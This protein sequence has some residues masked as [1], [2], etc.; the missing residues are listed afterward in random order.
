[1]RFFAILAFSTFLLG[2]QAIAQT[3]AE[4]VQEQLKANPNAKWHEVVDTGLFISDTFL[5]NGPTGEV[6][7][8]KGIAIKVGPNEEHTLVFD[9]ETM[10]MVAGFKGNVT[11][12]GTPWDGKH[13]G[14]SYFPEEASAYFFQT[15]MGPGWAIDG[16]WSDPREKDNGRP[17]GP[18]PDE[19]AEYLGLYRNTD[20]I[21]L[22]YTVGGSKVLEKPG[23]LGDSLLRTIQLE[24]TA[25]PTE[26]LISDPTETQKNVS[27]LNA[28]EGV[29]LKTLESGR[30]VVSIPA[31]I[32]GQ[33]HIVYWNGEPADTKVES[34]D[35]TTFTEG[36]P[37]MFPE[38]V[39]VS[40][41]LGQEDGTYAV[42]SI[43]LPTENPWKSQ[44]RFGGFDIFSDGD[45]A[46]CSTWN[47]DVWIAEGIGGDLDKVTWRRFASGLYQT[48][49]LKIVDDVVYTQGRDQIT[50]LHDL[51]DDGEAD[52]YEC[53]NNDVRIT[54]GFHE[55]TFDLQTDKE[56]NFY[57]TKAQ[58][59]LAGGRGFAP[60]TP[61]NGTILKISPDGEKLERVAW[62]IRA[63]GGI[64]V[65]PN[66]ELTT[67][68]NEGSY[69]PR[70]KI[71]WSNPDGGS[72]HG[73]VPSVWEEKAFV[74]TLDGA[75]TDY[76]RPLCWLPYYVDNSSGSQFW[77]PEDSAWKTHAGHMLHLSY[78]K[79]SVYRTLIDK[80]DGQVQGGVYRLPIELTT[81]AMRGRFHPESGNLFLIGFRGWQTNGGTGFQRVRY[82]GNEKPVPT[83]LKAHKNGIIVKFSKELDKEVASDPRRYAVSKWDYV[84]GPQYGSGR[85]SIDN[86]DDEA[87][88]KA[89]SEAS[90]G[91]QN[92]IDTVAVRA[93][94]LLGD[95]KTV[96]LYIPDMTPAMQM[97][98]K[99]DLVAADKEAFRETIWNT[100][101]NLRPDFGEHGLDL[102]NLP[103][104]NTEPVGEPG[105]I[106]SMAHGSTDD[107]LVV[108]RLAITLDVD[109]AATP[110]ID[111]RRGREMVFEG[112]LVVPSRDN[113]SFKMDGVGW[114]SL[115]I[116]GETVAEG[117]LP[118]T[119]DPIELEAGPHNIFCNFQRTDG[120][121]GKRTTGG[122][123]RLRLLWSGTDFVWEP[124]P[125]TAYRHLSNAV[126]EAKDKTRHGRD[127]FASVGCIRCHD[128]G[129]SVDPKKA[130]PE[131]L[132]TLP[133]FVNAGN[134]W[135]RGWVEEW[136]RKPEDRCPSV[137][138]DDAQ[139]IAAYL[140]TL[141][142]N[143]LAEQKG[144]AEKGKAL[145][146]SLHF[147]KWAEE[148][149]ADAKHT[150]AGLVAFLKDPTTHYADTTFPHLRLSDEE[151]GDLAAWIISNQPEPLKP[152]EG[153][154]AKGKEMVSKRCLVCHGGEEK[155]SYEF[156]A[157]PLSEMWQQEWLVHGCLSE[158]EG[159]APE[160]G[161]T[162]DEKQALLAFKNVDSNGGLRSLNRFV[163]HEYATRTMERIGCAECHSGENELP[164]I[165]FAGEKLRDEWLTGLFHGDVLRIRPYQ[166]ARMP[167]FPSR[168]ETLA[169][170]IAHGAGVTTGEKLT[171]PDPPLAEAGEKVSGLTGYACITCHAAGE[172]GAMQA[173]E[174]Q[175]PNLQLAGERLR[176]DYYMS[177]MHW[178]QRFVP[179]TIMPKYTADKETALNP[180][181]FEGNA[182]KQFEALW[183]WMQT[184]E[185]A[186]KAPVGEMH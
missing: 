97:E 1:M 44:P 9:S 91:S 151:A 168:A 109:Q 41:R 145:A 11:L 99:M 8:L 127:L 69:V 158:E 105:V 4:K 35:L 22:S 154:P 162:L 167:G 174:G 80:V 128:P 111:P 37:A 95:G 40:G 67:G 65:G 50:K 52:F 47:G 57:F 171:A 48:L 161:L 14:N 92:Q 96:F 121:V 10:R 112:S 75:P 140:D 73:V 38:T 175:G 144:D 62:G 130:M 115:K 58:P 148:L 60:W 16:D 45:R 108:D 147:T 134:R 138:P 101:H 71:T 7:V 157:K 51:N 54:E 118:I 170:G 113:L 66:G 27:L 18:L 26:V 98:I 84:W 129:K 85:F 160:L 13:G 5:K 110:F 104:I 24:K 139:H 46:A 42:D 20:G 28:P 56:G 169:K 76:E 172:K 122:E 31:G 185:G 163:P 135:H 136:V 176:E 124:I 107:A 49:G 123:G 72:F 53:F 131:L 29:E 183:Q 116:N 68:E 77:V 102:T 106:L 181:F 39:E 153:D 12:A 17:N 119:S 93:A 6:A 33:F 182:N 120:K 94:S 78:G 86:R 141:K 114:A 178:P 146:E 143:D 133:D 186:E 100:I 117:D 30:R 164:H 59:V 25:K 83:E 2:F 74:R 165:N 63:P 142:D 79:S 156:A 159:N 21:V 150:P 32:E 34:V 132:E 64:G 103:E 89:L 177:W 19:R 155:P 15:E 43:P 125:P 126:V 137:A 70:C 23:M 90:K 61:H 166:H 180:A 55:F 173:F 3:R 88:T 152:H 82:T 36:G 179:T 81:A 184:L 87:R 149:A